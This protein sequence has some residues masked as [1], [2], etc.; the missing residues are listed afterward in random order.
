[1]VGVLAES[2][3]GNSLILVRVKRKD[4]TIGFSVSSRSTQCSKVRVKTGW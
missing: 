4:N 3:R 2:V 1:M